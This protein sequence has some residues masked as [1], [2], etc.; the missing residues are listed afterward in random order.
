I[1]E[2]PLTHIRAVPQ[3]QGHTPAN[4]LP[5]PVERAAAANFAQQTIDEVMHLSARARKCLAR[6]GIHTLADLARRTICSLASIHGVGP[7]TLDEIMAEVSRI[8]MQLAVA[9]QA[10]LSWPPA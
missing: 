10:Q 8:G 1:Y 4:V 3:S 7:T 2:A 9:G 5:F 6:G